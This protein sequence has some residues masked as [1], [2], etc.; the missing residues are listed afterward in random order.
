MRSRSVVVPAVAFGLGIVFAVVAAD[1]RG[2]GPKMRALPKGARSSEPVLTRDQLRQ[3]VADEKR[4]DADKA[5]L[6]Q[7]TALSEAERARI[8]KLGAEIEALGGEVDDTSQAQVDAYN[9]LVAKHKEWVATFNADLPELNRRVDAGKA[10]VARFN[11]D[12][13]NRV[14]YD[15]DMDAIKAGK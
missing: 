12:C 14:Y 15:R 8:D 3:C 9:A 13:A 7:R 5:D 2:A 11:A 4:I 10:L 1:V 6:M